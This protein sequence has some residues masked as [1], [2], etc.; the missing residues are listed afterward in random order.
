MTATVAIRTATSRQ[1]A[2]QGSCVRVRRL[3]ARGWRSVVAF[4]LDPAGCRWL[5]SAAAQ[6]DAEHQHDDADAKDRQTELVGGLSG[7]VESD[8][9][10]DEVEL[11]PL[12]LRLVGD[13]QVVRKPS[14]A[15]AKPLN[16]TSAPRIVTR[17]ANSCAPV[18]SA[19]SARSAS[20]LCVRP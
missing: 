16:V 20:G 7:N 18:R 13:A 12:C 8:L 6:H 1:P 5:R 9:A 11:A 4:T 2:H 14:S 10:E 17:F 15:I 19:A 3:R